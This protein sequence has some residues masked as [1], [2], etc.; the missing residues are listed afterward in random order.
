MGT[1]IFFTSDEHYNHE[2]IITYCHRPFSSIGEMNEEIIR[3]FNEKVGKMDEAYHLGDFSWNDPSPFLKRLNGRHFLIK[4][5]HDEKHIKRQFYL[6][7]NVWDVRKIGWNGQKIWASHYAHARWPA[8]HMGRIHVFGHSHG[9]FPGV[10]RSMDVGVD[11]LN[12]FPISIEDVLKICEKKEMGA[13]PE[14]RRN[15]GDRD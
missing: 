15:Y 14:E 3:R 13:F 4:G 2:N 10:G 6:F 12:F 1:M 7:E 8:S 11:A 9:L 5:N